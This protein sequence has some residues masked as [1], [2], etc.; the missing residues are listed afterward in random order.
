MAFY[1]S[2]LSDNL[3]K[4]T[5]GF[6]VCK[7]V[8]IG[9]SGAIKYLDT[10][11]GI[12][13]DNRIVTVYRNPEENNNISTI[14]SFEGKP[15]TDGHP[16]VDVDATNYNYYQK[17]H[18]QNIRAD[19]DFLY[20][21]LF[22]T[23]ETL[24]NQ[25]LN[26]EKREVS[27]GYDTIYKEYNGNLYQTN[28]RGN[29]IAIVDEGRAGK[30][31]AIRDSKD[32][33]TKNI[34]RSRKMKDVSK[35]LRS[36]KKQIRDASTIEEVDDIVEETTDSLNDL[37]QSEEPM[38]VQD[39]PMG[40]EPPMP[41]A[42]GDPIAE[43]MQAIKSLNAKVDSLMTGKPQSDG[44]PEGDI[45][46]AIGDL[47]AEQTP[48][49]PMQPQPDGLT[50]DEDVIPEDDK[51]VTTSSAG[52]ELEDVVSV[53]SA[54]LEPSFTIEENETVAKD[55]AINILRN[56]RT[57]IA[58]I[59]N[60]IEKRRVADAILKSVKTAMK[61]KHSIGN[62]MAVANR[63]TADSINESK[64]IENAYAK[65]NPHMSKKLGA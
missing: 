36:F 32:T 7:N 38:P 25:I 26:K 53:D 5:E 16:D 40:A 59:S 15:V 39:N 27:C 55:T 60:P 63:K 22:I 52:K 47:G 58:N 13:Y 18:A 31:I 44:T 56:A 23:D 42:G 9:R 6:L 10:E 62:V 3:Y 37:M 12:G 34:K 35:I 21:D 61:T 64:R 29:H 50:M 28:I 45:D 1:G 43:V 20:A 11:L 65:L 41:N 4:T 33:I 51:G 14:A 48:Q 24:I 54:E 17:G 57:A 2:R 46:A 49:N 19:G 8:P 30:Q